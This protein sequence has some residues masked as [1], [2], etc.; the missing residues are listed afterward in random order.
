MKPDKRIHFQVKTS[1]I[2]ASGISD[3]GRQ[4]S[5]NED[6]IFLD[7]AGK[8]MLL[9]DGMGGHER[10]AEASETTLKIIREHL[11]PG[12]V[13]AGPQDIPVGADVPSEIACLLSV[14]DSAVNKANTILYQ[15][16]QEAGLQRYMG[17]TI[18]GLVLVESNYVLWFHIGD[19]RLY[20][21]RDSVL[22]ILTTDHSAYAEWIKDG[23]AGVEPPKNIITRAVGPQKSVTAEV[24]WDNWRQD[25]TY[26]LCSDGLSDML[27]EEQISQA[28][29]AEK[30]VADIANRL[31][32]A[33]NDAGGKDNVS[34]VV[35]RIC[36]P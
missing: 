33:A 31:I 9:A 4:R 14:I 25:D 27:T 11:D 26:L 5:E 2:V 13:S 34:V 21:W 30:D 29:N 35:C 17:T 36:A 15:R 32:E 18:V 20:R 22:K 10:G 28:F 3:I 16:S 12:V 7:K 6:S 8:F 24:E 1:C 19:S 23:R